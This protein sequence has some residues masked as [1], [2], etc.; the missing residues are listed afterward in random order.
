[1]NGRW[2]RF[3]WVMLLGALWLAGCEGDA[4]PTISEEALQIT[5]SILPQK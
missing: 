3:V 2:V 1:M 4:K 5:V